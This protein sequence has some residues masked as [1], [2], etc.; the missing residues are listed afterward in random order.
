MALLPTQWTG[1]AGIILQQYIVRQ[2]MSMYVKLRAKFSYIEYKAVLHF[3][4]ELAST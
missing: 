1:S 4:F 2:M 3:H